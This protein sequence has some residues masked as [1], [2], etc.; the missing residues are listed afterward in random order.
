MAK[1]L[2]IQA[3]PRR[4]S[5]SAQVAQE[6]LKT[7]LAGGQA[8]TVETLNLFDRSLP[9]FRAPQAAAKYQI[10]AG[11]PPQGE[12]AGAWKGVVEVVA[13]FESAD[14]ILISCPMWNFGIP[15]P[16]NPDFP[17][18]NHSSCIV[19]RGLTA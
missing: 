10:L 6:F 9:E 15:Y 8:A 1:I 3:S 4:E 12:A 7:Y 19:R 2:H 17:D 13:Q 14:I 18:E 5:I 11:Q 16:L